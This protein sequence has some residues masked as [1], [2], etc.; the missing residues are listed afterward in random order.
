MIYIVLFMI[1]S[2]L[3]AVKNVYETVFM[4]YSFSATILLLFALPFC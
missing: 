3:L 2:F 1:V 4:L